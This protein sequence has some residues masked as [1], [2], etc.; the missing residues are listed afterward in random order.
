M[1]KRHLVRLMTEAHAPR[2]QFERFDLPI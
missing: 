2:E 1:M